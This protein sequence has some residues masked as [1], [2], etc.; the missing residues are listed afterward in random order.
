MMSRY[1]SSKQ[2]TTAVTYPSPFAAEFAVARAKRRQ[3]GSPQGMVGLFCCEKQ[4]SPGIPSEDSGFLWFADEGELIAFFSHHL[5]PFFGPS[6]SC[7]DSRSRRVMERYLRGDLDQAQCR[8]ELNKLLEGHAEV[9]WWG[10]YSDLLK[11]QGLS[12]I[13][14]T[15]IWSHFHA[16]QRSATRKS[17]QPSFTRFVRYYKGE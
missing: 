3:P 7:D 13:F 9:C 15:V 16:G 12:G 17:R 8:D 5:V 10:P 14:P 11:G 1:F 4:L 6:N 2:K